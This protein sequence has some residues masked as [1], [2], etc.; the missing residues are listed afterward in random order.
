MIITVGGNDIA[1]LTQAG[2]AG[3]ATSE[4]WLRVQQWVTDV[5]EAVQWIKAPGRFPSGVFVIFANNYEFTD[6]TGD[7]ASCP[8]AGLSGFEGDAWEDPTAQEDM[9][10][11]AMEEYMRIATTTGDLHPSQCDRPPGDRRYVSRG[12]TGIAEAPTSAE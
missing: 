1:S 3:T 12:G 9:I 11:W 4:Q 6:A 8:A 10:V 5:E 7:V 2:S